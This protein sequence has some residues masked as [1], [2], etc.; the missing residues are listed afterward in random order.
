MKKRNDLYHKG[1]VCAHAVFDSMGVFVF[2]KEVRDA[3]HT[4]SLTL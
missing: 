4:A 2:C 3:N 1:T